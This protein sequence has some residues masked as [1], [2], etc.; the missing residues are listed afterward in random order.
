MDTSLFKKHILKYIQQIETDIV[1]YIQDKKKRSDRSAYYLSWT[2]EKLN[3]MTEEQFYEFITKLW[4]MLIWGNKKYIVDK[5]IA[6]N[7]SKSTCQFSTIPSFHVRGGNTG[8][9]KFFYPQ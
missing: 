3:S 4:A 2:P 8:F 9:A 7:T 1:T 6:D 5:L